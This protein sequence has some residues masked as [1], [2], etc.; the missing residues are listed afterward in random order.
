MHDILFVCV[1]GTFAIAFAVWIAA[2]VGY[3]RKERQR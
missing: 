2:L 1:L 3:L